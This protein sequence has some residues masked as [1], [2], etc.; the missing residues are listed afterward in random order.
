MEKFQGLQFQHNSENC[1]FSSIGSAH[2]LAHLD[3][4]PRARL[5]SLKKL[6]LNRNIMMRFW[7]SDINIEQNCLK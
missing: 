3:T 4:N 1:R 6:Q 5:I 2:S 7:S